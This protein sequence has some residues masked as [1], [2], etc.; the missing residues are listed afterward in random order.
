MVFVAG[1]DVPAVE[2]DLASRKVV[3][4]KQPDYPRYGDIKIDCRNPI[5]SVRLEI[6]PELAHL[7]PALE[8][9]IRVST[10]LER[11]DLSEVAKQQG[12]RPLGADNAYR[13]II[14]VKNKD[15]T[16]KTGLIFSSNH[17]CYVVL[18]VASSSGEME[19]SIT[20]ASMLRVM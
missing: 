11:D 13:H 7:T 8:I 2:F 15:A 12:K 14:L 9:I 19:D 1:E 20:F 10:L 3:V 5:V 6:T 4:E 17:I 18:F 16:I